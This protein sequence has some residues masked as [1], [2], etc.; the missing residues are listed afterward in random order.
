MKVFGTP[1][2]YEWGGGGGGRTPMILKTVDFT[3]FNFGRP[4]ELSMRG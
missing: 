1:T 3:N 4:L 2:F